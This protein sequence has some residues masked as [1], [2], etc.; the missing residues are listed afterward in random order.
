MP[1]ENQTDCKAINWEMTGENRT[2]TEAIEKIMKEHPEM[3]NV[4][5]LPNVSG[6][7]SRIIYD[8]KQSNL[9][10]RHTD[11]ETQIV[12]DVEHLNWSGGNNKTEVS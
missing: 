9:E 11:N 10:F 8:A 1:G 2:N 12:Y 3:C 7:G 6:N 4:T 5:Y